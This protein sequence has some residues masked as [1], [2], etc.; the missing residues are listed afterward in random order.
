MLLDNTSDLGTEVGLLVLSAV[1]SRSWKISLADLF[2]NCTVQT[3]VLSKH[4][5]GYILYIMTRVAR[6]QIDNTIGTF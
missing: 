5:I 4:D 2:L 6:V 1:R 3:Q